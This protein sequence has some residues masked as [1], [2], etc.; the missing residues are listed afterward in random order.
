MPE[1]IPKRV[2]QK[3]GNREAEWGSVKVRQ[4]YRARAL[5]GVRLLDKSKSVPKAWRMLLFAYVY[6]KGSIDVNG[7]FGLKPPLAIILPHLR[8]DEA[9]EKIGLDLT[10]PDA[11]EKRGF[12]PMPDAVAKYANRVWRDEAEKGRYKVRD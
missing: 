10:D 6:R 11:G 4:R 1:E 12:G 9:L 3:R 7:R 5:S 8:H 2:F